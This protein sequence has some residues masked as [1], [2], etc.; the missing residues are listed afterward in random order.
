MP[1][2][3]NKSFYCR[4][5]CLFNMFR[6]PLCPSS[7]AQ[8]YYTV[9]AAC[10]ILCCGFQVAGLVWSWGLYVRW[11]YLLFSEM[12]QNRDWCESYLLL[13]Q[14]SLLALITVEV[15]LICNCS[16]AF[17]VAEHISGVVPSTVTFKMSVEKNHA[18][19]VHT[20]LTVPRSNLIFSNIY[21][22]SIKPLLLASCVLNYVHRSLVWLLSNWKTVCSHSCILHKCVSIH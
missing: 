12:Y 20:A 7:G 16:H 8:E 2:R 3:C 14:I 19:S 17:V 11:Q 15:I 6:A 1:T 9:V 13:F 18:F 10:G 21:E 4:S 22:T 5:Y